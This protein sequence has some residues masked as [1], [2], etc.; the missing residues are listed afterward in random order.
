ME[1]Y[2]VTLLGFTSAEPNKT[3]LENLF[4]HNYDGWREAFSF[5]VGGTVKWLNKHGEPVV[6]PD[7]PGH[8]LLLYYFDYVLEKQV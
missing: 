2:R 5:P 8:A 6:T 4:R 3:R 1:P 7:Y